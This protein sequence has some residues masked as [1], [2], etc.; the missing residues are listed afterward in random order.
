MKLSVALLT[1]G[2]VPL[3]QV[4]LAQS[5]S[6]PTLAGAAAFAGPKLGIAGDYELNQVRRAA[7]GLDSGVNKRQGGIG[8]L[9]YAG[10]DVA[11][12]T[13]LLAGVELGIGKGGKTLG[14]GLS[15]GTFSSRPGLSIDISG[16][17]GVVLAEN[18]LLYGRAGY[19]RQSVRDT[20]NF[21]SP[22]Q[23]SIKEKRTDGGF[24]YGVGVE[25]AVSERIALRAELDQSYFSKRYISDRVLLGFVVHL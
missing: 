25:L 19:A 24:I 14:E 11:L 3:A 10:Y 17:A 20:T 15:G 9:G 18:M 8:Y 22:G 16:R 5:T 6:D 23:A 4:A 2:L 7:P 13:Q 12:G 1:L 21:T